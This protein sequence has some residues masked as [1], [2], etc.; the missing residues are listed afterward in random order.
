VG[1]RRPK[2]RYRVTAMARTGPSVMGLRLLC[3]S[4]A[5]QR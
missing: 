5:P 1:A 4:A 2:T 3:V